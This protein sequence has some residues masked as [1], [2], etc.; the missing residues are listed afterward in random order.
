M[1]VPT[2]K[3]DE[4]MD[5]KEIVKALSTHFETAPRYLGAP[6]FAYEVETSGEVYKI[7]RHGIITTLDGTEISLDE[8]MGRQPIKEQ[9]M[10]TQNIENLEMSLPMDGHSGAT[11]KNIVNMIS[12]KQHLIMKSMGIEENLM[13]ETFAEDLSLKTTMSFDEFKTA[14]EELGTERCKGIKFDFEKNIYTYNIPL[15]DYVK[16]SAFAVL[17]T[18]I[19]ENAKE[20]KRTSYKAAQEDN[21]K[22]AFR[23]WLIRLGMKGDGYKDVRR[24]LLENLEGN[25][26]FRKPPNERSEN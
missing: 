15:T 8:V 12:S 14:I 16:I 23:T 1:Y 24:V 20:Q 9:S 6:S 22:F 4:V 17:V 19:N 3:G 11:L 18:R 25:G 2:K 13:D 5:R 21:P 10:E 7:D 26:A